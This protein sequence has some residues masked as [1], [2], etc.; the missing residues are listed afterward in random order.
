MKELLIKKCLKCGA[1]IEVLKDCNCNDC[2]IMCCGEQMKDVKFNS[3]DAAVE[4]HIPTYE[5]KNNE[6][7]VTVNHVME[8]EHYIEWICY[9]TSKK[10]MYTYF[11]KGE[12][13]TTI[14]P[15][16]G[17]GYIYSSCNKHGIW[18]NSID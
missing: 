2:G 13:A 6:I 14:F 15:Y 12:D 17:K 16:N 7:I 9:K 3:V 8:E 18:K 10:E 1:Q 4:K 5:I 11:N